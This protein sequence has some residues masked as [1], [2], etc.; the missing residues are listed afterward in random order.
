MER[1]IWGVYADY[2]ALVKAFARQDKTAYMALFPDTPEKLAMFLTVSLDVLNS[3]T[4]GP[5]PY[6]DRK[7]AEFTEFVKGLDAGKVPPVEDL[8]P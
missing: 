2:F 5:G 7:F 6:Q 4:G 1:M 3:A 8:E